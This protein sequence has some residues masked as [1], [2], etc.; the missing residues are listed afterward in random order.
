MIAYSIEAALASGCFDQVVVS[1]DDDEIREIANKFGASTPF[2]RPAELA[3]DEAGTMPVVEHALMELEKTQD[4]EYVCLIYPTAPLLNPHDIEA[5]FKQLQQN[6]ADYVFSAATYPSPIQRAFTFEK[7]RGV[8]MLFPENR[9]KRSQELSEAYHD[10]AQFYWGTFAAFRHQKPVFAEG[11]EIYPIPRWR[12]Q[13]I[14]T[15]EDWDLAER[16]YTIQQSSQG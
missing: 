3:T 15:Q 1:T 8:E 12:V 5:A 14:D 9:D 7:G 11:A 4:I 13:D 2:I 16:L 6:K 10:A